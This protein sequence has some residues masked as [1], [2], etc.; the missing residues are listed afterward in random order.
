L[1]F[2]PELTL[3][4]LEKKKK[5]RRYIVLKALKEGREEN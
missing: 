1:F 5:R 3:V 2:F 4:E